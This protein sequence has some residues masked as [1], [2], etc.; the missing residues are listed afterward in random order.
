MI[1][2]D[3][4]AVLG[5]SFPFDAEIE[6]ALLGSIIIDPTVLPGAQAVVTSTDFYIEVNS[7]VFVVLCKMHEQGLAIN[8]ATLRT[9]LSPKQIAHTSLPFDQLER[10][11]MDNRLARYTTPYPSPME[12]E[13]YARIV[14]RDS[15]ARTCIRMYLRA[16]E[17]L[18]TNGL[19]IQELL[20]RTVGKLQE[21]QEELSDGNN[22]D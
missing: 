5:K 11:E 22:P 15:I 21:Y 9:F 18:V 2:K 20:T 3:F 6:E 8:E 13:T 14:R 4:K 7:Q 16:I 19:D 12:W 10:G 17:L 1:S